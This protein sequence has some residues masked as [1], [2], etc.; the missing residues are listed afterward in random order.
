ML[1]TSAWAVFPTTSVLDD[2][3]RANENPLSQGGNWPGPTYS[4]LSTLQLLSN[5]VG[6][7]GADGSRYRTETFGPNS[8]AFLTVST[9]GTASGHYVG[10]EVRVATPNT[11]TIDTYEVAIE[12]GGV[13]WNAV[14]VY[15]VTNGSF[16]QLGATIT[17]S[18]TAGD[19]LGEEIIGSGANNITVYRRSGS[20][21]SSLGQRSDA[22]ITAAGNISAVIGSTTPRIDD[23]G[24]GT[25]VVSAAARRRTL[26]GVGE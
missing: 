9:L 15:E 26:V 13:S 12:W 25:I 17:Q 24:G 6:S 5:V 2:F 3:N 4:G 19:G 7:T 23:F 16:A 8:E 21:W 11:A 18:W 10:V 14:T 1:E 22:T 20:T